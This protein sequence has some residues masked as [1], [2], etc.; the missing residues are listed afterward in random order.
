MVFIISG[1]PVCL[2][3]SEKYIKENTSVYVQG[4][5]VENSYNGI[6]PEG[7]DIIKLPKY[8]MFQGE[9]FKEDDYCSAIAEVQEAIRKYDQV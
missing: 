4:V 2:W 6:V 5:E 3:L 7:F 9:P 1:E 8:L